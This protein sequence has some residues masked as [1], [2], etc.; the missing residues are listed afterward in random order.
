MPNAFWGSVSLS[1]TALSRI[2]SKTARNN[3]V[4]FK[5]EMAPRRDGA[6]RDVQGWSSAPSL[7]PKGH[8]DRLL[9]AA[10]LTRHPS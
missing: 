4:R 9:G 3:P 2:S 5:K 10:V 7:L 6:T 8:A 1:L